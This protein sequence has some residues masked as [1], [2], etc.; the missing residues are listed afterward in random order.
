MIIQNLFYKK[1]TKRR[2][3][4][5]IIGS[6]MMVAIVASVGSI[7]LFQGMNGINSFNQYLEDILRTQSGKSQESFII[8]HVRFQ[9]NSKNVE[10]T[11][12]NTGFVDLYVNKI[13]LVRID[14]QELVIYAVDRADQVRMTDKDT[15]T[16]AA[17]FSGSDFITTT[18][19]TSNYN[20]AV[21]TSEGN[22]AQSTVYPFNT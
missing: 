9:P 3:V 16:I 10:F 18:Y 19:G 1:K 7:L 2:A 6:V 13:V 11:I 22:L 15:I 5:Q 21:T 4:S 12:R 14:T 20:L 8:E 17:T